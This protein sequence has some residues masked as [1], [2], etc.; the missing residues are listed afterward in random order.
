M[1]DETAVRAAIAAERSDLATVL[2]ALTPDQWEAP[3]LCTGWRVREV[4]AH[5]AMA[6]RY[7]LPQVVVEMV[8][9]RGK[10]DTM[11]DRAARRDAATL[12][13]A[14]LTAAIADNVNHPWKPPGGGFEGALSH[15][16]IHGLDITVALGLG[17]RVPLDRLRMVVDSIK[18]R[19]VKFFGV[20]LDG[21]QL[22]ADDT[23]WTYGSGEPVVGA[24]QDLLLVLCGRK[25]PAGH[26]RGA[27][28]ARFT[29]P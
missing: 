19:Q 14:E 27:A 22:S 12:S 4:V 16:L 18:P 2:A 23:D 11:A 24:V 6:F 9:A 17:R 10:F 5:I 29:Q 15:D 13:T 25:L 8:K 7:S 28:S 26:L 1:A 3:S 20:D 21:V